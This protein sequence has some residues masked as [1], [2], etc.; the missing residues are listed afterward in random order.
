M[1]ILLRSGDAGLQQGQHPAQ[2]AAAADAAR[3]PVR[4]VLVGNKVE[5]N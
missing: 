2:A 4:G 3:V 5:E 1:L